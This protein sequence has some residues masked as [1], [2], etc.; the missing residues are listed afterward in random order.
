MLES[1]EK[2]LDY[3][4]QGGDQWFAE[5][6]W[7]DAIAKRVEQVTEVAKYQ[8]PIGERE[9]YP[10]IPWDE[11]TGTRD[12]FVHAYQDLDVGILREIV[13]TDMPALIQAIRKLDIDCEQY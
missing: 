9:K 4:I 13:E 11:V 7:V 5:D 6:H 2:V 1:A 12:R 8:F 10:D 3:A